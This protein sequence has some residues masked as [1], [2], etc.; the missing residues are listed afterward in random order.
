MPARYVHNAPVHLNG[1]IFCAVDTETTGTNPEAHSIIEVCILPLNGDYSINKSITPFTTLMQPIPGRQIEQDALRKN[2]IS[3]PEIM[4]NCLD[5]DRVADLLVEWFEKL[6]MPQGKR[7]VPLAHNWPFDKS[8]LISWLG[9][10]TYELI[11][12]Y[13]YRDS[14]ALAL[15]INDACDARNE[16][17]PFPKVGVG[18]LAKHFGIENP[19]P[20]RALGDCVTTAQVYRK[21]L[22]YR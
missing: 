9:P 11:F 14:M 19:A 6:R 2:K 15:S 5:A 1:N 4:L 17:I 12:D 8:F 3:L 22:E 7:I 16:R 10:L 13:H 21:L 20:H 18:A